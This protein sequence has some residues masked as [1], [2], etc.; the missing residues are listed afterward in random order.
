M[1]ISGRG[2]VDGYYK[3]MSSSH[4]ELLGQTALTM[5]SLSLLEHTD[6][7]HRPIIFYADNQ[8]VQSKSGSLLIRKLH[9]QRQPNIDLWLGYEK[10]TK[11]LNKKAE[12][13]RGHQD[14]NREWM[15]I[16][17]L[18]DLSLSPAAYLNI[19]CDCQAEVA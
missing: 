15:D 1:H 17:D 2:P 16:T 7:P 12:W 14:D 10:S 6:K 4:E 8:G 3:D 19:W 9:D 11:H 18:R 13:I 5:I